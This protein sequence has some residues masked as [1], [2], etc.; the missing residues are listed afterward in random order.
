MLTRRSKSFDHNAEAIQAAMA[1][2]SA[3]SG[4]A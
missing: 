1:A 3:K 2:E 4:T